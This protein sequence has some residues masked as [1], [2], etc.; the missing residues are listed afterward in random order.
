[1]RS[2]LWVEK[3]FASNAAIAS[4]LIIG[5]LAVAAIPTASAQQ[6]PPKTITRAKPP[7]FPA[8][9]S[10]FFEDAF[11][12]GLVGG[13]PADLSKA[14]VAAPSGGAA[15]PM[16][17][18]GGPTSG[19]GW[20]ALIS[21]TTIEDEIKALKLVIDTG[22]TT[23]S[24]FAGRGYKAARRD[25][26]MLAMLFAVAGDYD[27]EV[28]WKKDAPAARDII[29]RT[30]ANSKVGTSQVFQEA[31]LRKQELQDLL[32]GSSPYAGKEAETKVTWPNVCDRSPLMMHLENI[33]EPRLK[34][35][36]A[37]KGSFTANADKILHDAEIIAVIGDVLTKEGMMDADDDEYKVFCEQMKKA[38]KEIA[39]AV[40]LKNFEA[41]S[42]ASTEIGKACTACHENYRS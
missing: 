40:R 21:P 29:G 5:L 37:D 4:W 19:T 42:S 7:A 2:N 12:D 3:L 25:F 36:L 9:D 24:D 20:S 33:Y 39:E 14:V 8:N 23:P 11:R 38:G 34:P 30:A 16:A 32:S 13:R 41:A 28:R 27:G 17:N 10:T 6:K 22:I 1:M 26:S 35:A 18:A 31:K 15:A